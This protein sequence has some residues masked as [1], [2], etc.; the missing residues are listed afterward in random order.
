[1][2]GFLWRSGISEL[3]VT[4]PLCTKRE[5]S[6]VTTSKSDWR[7][8]EEAV[9]DRSGEPAEGSFV[10]LGANLPT[11]RRLSASPKHH[12]CCPTAPLISRRAEAWAKK[13]TGL[14]TDE[15]MTDGRSKSPGTTKLRNGGLL[16]KFPPLYD[17]TTKLGNF[18]PLN[19]ISCFLSNDKWERKTCQTVKKQPP[20]PTVKTQFQTSKPI[21]ISEKCSVRQILF[22][23]DHLN[24]P[25]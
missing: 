13:L 4:H 16:T 17:P 5:G 20:T 7:P 24:A 1:M 23:V 10:L 3:R 22:I 8:G 14:W 25:H 11:W 6:R 12:S 2:K 18:T 15:E 19:H 9:G 21:N